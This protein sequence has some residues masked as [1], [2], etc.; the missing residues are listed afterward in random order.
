MPWA[1]MVLFLLVVP[2]DKYS[3]SNVESAKRLN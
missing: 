3:K 2:K 1:A